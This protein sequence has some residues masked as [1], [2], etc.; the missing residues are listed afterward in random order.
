M[1]MSIRLAEPKDAENYS[2]W[3][4]ADLPI[5]HADPNAALAAQAF[6]AV[7][8]QEGEPILMQ[9]AKP[10]LMLEAIAPKTGITPVESARAIREM[11]DGMKRVA[12][13]H[14]FDE[15]YFSSDF[16]PFKKMV[17]KKSHKKHGIEKVNLTVYR[18]KV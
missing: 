8:E 5:S 11:F 18:V 3:L 17:E 10:V 15:I 4:K 12:K 6:T 14:G 2:K 16:P 1:K 7:V 9:T 13:A